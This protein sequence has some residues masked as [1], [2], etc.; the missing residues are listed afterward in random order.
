VSPRAGLDV[1]GKSRPTGIRSPNRPVRRESLYRLSH[2]GHLL[3]IDHNRDVSPENCIYQTKCLQWKG[4]CTLLHRI[5]SFHCSMNVSARVLDRTLSFSDSWRPALK[6]NGERTAKPL[7]SA[8]EHVR[9]SI[10]MAVGTRQQ[11]KDYPRS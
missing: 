6:T 8:P 10:D 2:T 3:I 11:L 9:T 5:S 4:S 7:R 1:Y